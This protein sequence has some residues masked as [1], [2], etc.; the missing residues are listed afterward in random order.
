MGVAFETLFKL[1]ALLVVRLSSIIVRFKRWIHH[2]PF[3]V[4]WRFGFFSCLWGSSGNE[5][6][7][8]HIRPC[9]RIL[10]YTSYSA[11]PLVTLALL[12]V[13]FIF[14]NAE[15]LHCQFFLMHIGLTVFFYL[16]HVLL[17]EFKFV[18][19]NINLPA[20][21]PTES[22]HNQSSGIRSLGHP[23]IYKISL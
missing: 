2:F 13:C 23:S 8:S 19:V 15:R 17:I 18:T 9:Q 21:S 5:T 16:L 4:P 12:W 3:I 14:R 22:S 20:N 11:C 1:L 10:N 6:S 7:A